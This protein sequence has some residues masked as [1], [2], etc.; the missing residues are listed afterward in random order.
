MWRD[1]QL[2]DLEPE[3]RADKMVCKVVP[4]LSNHLLYGST[5]SQSSQSA[6]S[7]MASSPVRLAAQEFNPFTDPQPVLTHVHIFKKIIVS[8][9]PR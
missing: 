4:L 1:L 6:S 7:S 3:L 8:V 5:T 9:I 2:E